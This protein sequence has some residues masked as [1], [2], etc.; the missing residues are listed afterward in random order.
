MPLLKIMLTLREPIVVGP[1]ITGISARVGISSYPLDGEDYAGLMN[2][3]RE[4]EVWIEYRDRLT[5]RRPS[6]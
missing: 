2:A 4:N 3:A 6:Y 5:D 1:H